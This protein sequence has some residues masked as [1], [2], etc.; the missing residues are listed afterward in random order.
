MPLGALFTTFNGEP[1]KNI[2]QGDLFLDF[3][4]GTCTDSAG[5]ITLMNSNL[6]Y[7]NLTQCNSFSIFASDADTGINVG[8]ALT[9]SDHQ[10]THTID[11]YAFDQIRISIPSLSL[12][13]DS[14]Q[15]MFVGSTNLEMNY[16]FN[17]FAHFRDQ[18]PTLPAVATS[19]NTFT[20][21]VSHH[22]G[23]YDQILYT[24][25]NTHGSN[26]LNV[27]VQF[28]ENNVDW[29]DAQGYTAATGVTI[30]A[31]S[32]D[33]FATDIT[34]HFYRVQIQSTSSGNHAT[35]QIFWNYVSLNN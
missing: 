16:I 21:Y 33:A 31:G 17:N 13:T 8:N 22:V 12:P 2:P 14:N 4:N 6:D 27:K 24:I 3:R 19:T 29:F 32:Y 35:F 30:A 26:S 28:S 25:S 20:E 1:I 5:T 18:Y 10:L 9:I 7:Y 11:S 23:G 34:H 15:I